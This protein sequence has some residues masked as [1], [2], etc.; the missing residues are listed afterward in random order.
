MNG[1]L[2]PAEYYIETI[3]EGEKKL[4]P[5]RLK[6]KALGWT[7][8]LSALGAGAF[9]WY[10]ITSG[11]IPFIGVSLL[12]FAVFLFALSTDI[13]NDKKIHHQQTLIELAKEEIRILQHDYFFRPDGRHAQTSIHAYAQDLDILG[14]A[15][16]F[17]YI[18]RAE[19]EPGQ[20][21]MTQWLLHPADR[22]LILERQ[23]ALRVLAKDPA[24]LSG[25]QALGRLYP[26]S[27]NTQI[28]V[29]QW[30]AE[31][32]QFLPHKTYSLLRWILPALSLSNVVIYF[33][34]WIPD[35]PFYLF[36]FLFFILSLLFSRRVMP[37]YTRLNKIN[38]QL[39]TLTNGL[40]HLENQNH[41]AP[42][43]QRESAR[44][45][46]G[47]E[48]ASQILQRL[49]KI[50]D[51]LDYRLNPLVFLPL[52]TLLFWDL[53]QVMTLEKWKA[54]YKDN[55]LDWFRVYGEM[56]ALASLARL[57]FNHP[58]WCMPVIREEAGWFQV[59]ELGHPLIASPKR[60]TS[61]IRLAGKG[62][63]AL[64]TGSNMAGKS[65]FLRSVG[66]NT[67][68]AM[69]GAPVCAR[70]MNLSLWKVMSSMRISDNLEES[71]S[72]FY[73][74]LKKLKS[75]IEAVNQKQPILILLDEILRG[76]NSGDRHKGS[77]AL[78]HQLIREQATGLIATH[79]LELAK[80][81]SDYPDQIHNYH[82]DVQ[83]EGEELYFDYR[84]KE[85][86]CQS[87]NASLLMKKIGID[88]A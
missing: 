22:S 80:L 19:S 71:T 7:R 51:R 4:K 82:F 69:A 65:T 20:H 15:S 1:S 28:A 21:T 72:T 25:L 10:A 73:A 54:Q 32:L 49:Q 31:P 13:D 87:M 41:S 76:T 67:V 9:L 23:A 35:S 88:L 83:V 85:G 53:Q 78:I 37:A 84:L 45:N 16:L 86:V 56:E 59:T 36:L 34:G 30:I 58:D 42:L 18:N 38:D 44:L 70:E 43:L 24:W 57:H 29:S 66:V 79:D 27:V 26:V 68:L 39:G 61:S 11:M 64:I 81:A 74:E 47:T 12:L 52:N 17:Q 14:H 77:A 63:L 3:R 55:V 50:M 46:Q 5:L 48:K 40:A 8:L 75:I 6:S 62:Q 60:V 33:L 2:K